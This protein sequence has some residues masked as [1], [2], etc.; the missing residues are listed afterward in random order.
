MS[1]LTRRHNGLEKPIHTWVELYAGKFKTYSGYVGNMSFSLEGIKAGVKI[2]GVIIKP[3]LKA[4]SARSN[5]IISTDLTP[6]AR[7]HEFGRQAVVR[8]RLLRA[9]EVHEVLVDWVDGWLL[10]LSGGLLSMASCA[11]SCTLYKK[12]SSCDFVNNIRERVVEFALV[13]FIRA[14]KVRPFTAGFIEL[15][16]GIT[17]TLLL[18]LVSLPHYLRWMCIEA[19]YIGLQLMASAGY[20]PRIAPQAYEKLLRIQSGQLLGRVRMVEEVD[21]KVVRMLEMMVRMAY[22]TPIPFHPHVN[23]HIFRPKTRAHKSNE[24]SQIKGQWID[25]YGSQTST[26]DVWSVLEVQLRKM[27]SCGRL[28]GF[29][30]QFWSKKRRRK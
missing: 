6:S 12:E 19:N 4:P 16:L 14:R 21:F 27:W 5:V 25:V 20:D 26:M 18:S 24:Q 23:C 22:L 8:L 9:F 28:S 13:E 1:N 3:K 15:G 2:R 10:N 29:R 30:Q 17:W 7:L 11:G